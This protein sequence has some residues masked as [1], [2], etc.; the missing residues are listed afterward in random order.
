MIPALYKDMRKWVKY[1]FILGLVGLMTLAASSVWCDT[2]STT[3]L[4]GL[5]ADT[6]KHR[7]NLENKLSDALK[8][9]QANLTVKENLD[10]QLQRAE[11]DVLRIRGE[12]KE[13]QLRVEFLN[14]FVHAT[15]KVKNFKQETPA[16]LLQLA[17]RQISSGVEFSNESRLWIFETYLS[18][19]IRDLYEP[20]ENLAQFVRN[21]M[22]YSTLA[23]P[24]SPKGFI[25]T[26]D[27]IGQKATKPQKF[28]KVPPG[29][30]VSWTETKPAKPTIPM[31]TFVKTQ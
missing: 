7:A 14:S 22:D 1:S 20:T 19:A 28:K 23:D 4:R 24:R 15:S 18:M 6:T 13:T 10:V 27:Y 16:I 21:F 30:F 3:T 31:G 8:K 26:R 29:S 25:K 9:M 11:E 2:Q 12:I 5:L 17:Q